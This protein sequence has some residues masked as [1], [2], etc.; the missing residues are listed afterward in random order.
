MKRSVFPCTLFL[1]CSLFAQTPQAPTELK[2]TDVV[3]TVEGKPLTVADVNKIVDELPPQMRTNYNR[4]PKG[5]LD[6]WFLLIR[7]SSM[8]E[9]EKL[10][11]QS[12]FKE[13]LRITHMNVLAQ[14]TLENRSKQVQ[15]L[16]EDQKKYYEE[17]KDNYTQAK[18]KIIYVAF[19]DKPAADPNKKTLTEAAAS[20]KAAG[21]V[22]RARAGE[23]F[24]KLV[25]ANSE[26]TTSVEKDGDFGPIKRTDNLPDNIRTAIFSLKKGDISEPVRAPNGFYIFRLEEMLPVAFD[27]VRDA[28]FV[29]IKNLRFREWMDQTQKTVQLQV[30]NP[31]FFSQGSAQR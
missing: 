27:D 24:V 12:P 21:L 20:E 3:A 7:L 15:I 1:A 25:K 13:S 6:Q 19:S 2:P 14:A 8:A 5:F 22:K 26:D 10:D 30:K 28:I 9:K 23:D 29:E 18:L 16:P 17:H 31:A 4:D 11:E